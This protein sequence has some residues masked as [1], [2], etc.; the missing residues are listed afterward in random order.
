MG[1]DQLLAYEIH[2][3]FSS[4]NKIIKFLAIS[5]ISIFAPL[6]N[7]CS[8]PLLQIMSTLIYLIGYKWLFYIDNMQG[9]NKKSSNVN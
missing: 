7:I 6:E 9:K 2:G 8:T 1:Q 4:S 5:I 3:N